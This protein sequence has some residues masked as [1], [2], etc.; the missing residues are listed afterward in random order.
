MFRFVRSGSLFR[1]C[2]R[3]VPQAGDETC[4]QATD[5]CRLVDAFRENR[6]PPCDATQT[7]PQSRNPL[8]AIAPNTAKL[9]GK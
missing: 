4:T 9:I 6:R 8:L 2:R 1:G 5:R 3:V 7:M